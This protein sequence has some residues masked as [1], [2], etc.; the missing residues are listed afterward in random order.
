[1]DS[2]VFAPASRNSNPITSQMAEAEITKTGKRQTLMDWCLK[3]VKDSPGI[4]AGDMEELYGKHR[5]VYAKRLSDL[6]N[7]GYIV[8]GK[9]RKAQG[10]YQISWWPSESQGMLW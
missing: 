9:P 8:A 2:I 1:M 5:S 6:K 10:R 7:L 3:I 4:T